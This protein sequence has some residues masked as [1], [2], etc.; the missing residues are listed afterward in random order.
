MPKNTGKS[1]ASGTTACGRDSPV[2]TL[3]EAPAFRVRMG[4]AHSGRSPKIKGFIGNIKAMVRQHG[5]G[6]STRHRSSAGVGGSAAARIAP[7]THPQRVV[8]KARVVKHS[9]FAARKGGA[10]SA[11][12][13]HMDYL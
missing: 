8:V 4:T 9:K 10:M 13:K 3:I 7:R 2:D 12:A 5:G 1:H 11:L 6:I